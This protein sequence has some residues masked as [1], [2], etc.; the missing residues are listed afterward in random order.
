MGRAILDLGLGHG[1]RRQGWIGS[2]SHRQTSQHLVID[3][4]VIRV[5]LVRALVVG[6]LDYAVL[7]QFTDALAAEGVPA[8]ERRR[9]LIVMIIRLEANAAFE[10]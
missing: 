6:A 4:Q 3:W 2:G 5:Y 1:R 10:N 8:G 7:G 9:L